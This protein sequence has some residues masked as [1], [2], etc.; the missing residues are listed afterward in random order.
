LGGHPWFYFVEYE[1]DIDA[2]LQK[3]REREFR[4]GRYNPAVDFPV[5]PVGPHSPSPG[6]QHASIEEALEAS[7]ADGTRSILD[8]ERVGE[9]PD[10]GVVTPVPEDE[11]LRAFGTDKP[12]REMIE[13]GV[14]LDAVERGQGIC[15]VVY[16]GGQP[17]EI[18]FAGYSFD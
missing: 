6:A 11:L 8:M 7:D 2:A 4:A 14:E 9:T 13:K 1:P 15:I 3:L 16:E 18:F 17:S 12:T 10:Y 5:F